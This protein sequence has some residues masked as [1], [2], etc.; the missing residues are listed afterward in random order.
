VISADSTLSD[1]CIEVSAALERYGMRGVL[2]GGS[3]AALYA[4]QADASEDADFVVRNDDSLERI[5]DAMKSIDF[6]RIGRS[7]IF[8]HLACR[9]TVDFPKGPLAVGGDYIRETSVMTI[10]RH[11]LHILSRTDCVRD[12]LSQFYFWKDLTALNAAVAVAATEPDDV[13]MELLRRWTERE[14]QEYATK[15]AEFERRLHASRP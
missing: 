3:A 1:V 15:F 10:G 7:R 14:G 11:H 5:A 12:R 4:P 13:D 8:S 6:R 2:T 9:Y